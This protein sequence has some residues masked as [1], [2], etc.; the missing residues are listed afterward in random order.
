M[1]PLRSGRNGRRR[2]T[3]RA[4]CTA[5][6]RSPWARPR[7][8]WVDSNSG[9]A[10]SF[11]RSTDVLSRPVVGSWAVLRR[12]FRRIES[13]TF[14]PFGFRWRDEPPLPGHDW[15][16]RGVRLPHGREKLLAVCDIGA[17]R[18]L[19]R[20]DKF[21]CPVPIAVPARDAFAAPRQA[22]R[23]RPGEQQQ[24]L[25]SRPRGWCASVTRTN[26]SDTDV[27]SGLS[28]EE[29]K[30]HQDDESDDEFNPPDTVAC[31]ASVYPGTMTF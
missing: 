22:A 4:S 10:N 23:T 26:A 5:I 21:C 29:S 17:I 15:P 30:T 13:R 18:A 2:T 7:F 11:A 16:F 27:R 6:R 8:R 14:D 25:F 19:P 3:I 9:A 20:V 12:G 1:T 28:R 24:V 31:H